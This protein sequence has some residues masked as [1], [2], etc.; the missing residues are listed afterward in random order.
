VIDAD[1]PPEEVFA[2]VH[3]ILPEALR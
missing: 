1:G 3:P 2:R